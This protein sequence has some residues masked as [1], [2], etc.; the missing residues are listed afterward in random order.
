M[1]GATLP[2][3]VTRENLTMV[4]NGQLPGQKP[5]PPERIGGGYEVEAPG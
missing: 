3:G 2:G 4:K 5:R 1:Y